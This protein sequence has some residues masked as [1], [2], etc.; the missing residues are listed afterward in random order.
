VRRVL[1]LWLLSLP[2][3]GESFVKGPYLQN[4][5]RN[6]ITVMWQSDAS[7]PGTVSIDGRVIEAPPATIHEVRVEGLQPGRRYA[8]QVECGGKTSG[9]ELATAPEPAEPFSFVVFGDTRSN[10]DSHR[11]MVERVRREVPDFFLLTGDMVDDGSRDT[12]WQT[13]FQI[14]REL[15][16]DNVVYPAVGNHDRQGRARTADAFRRFF[17]VP[18]D[19]PDPERYYSFK[20][21]NARFFVLD[22]NEYSFALTDQTAWLTREL[23]RAAADPEVVH[24][25]VVMHHPPFS[26]S[27]HGGHSELREMWTPIFERY[28]VD[29]V[30]SG[31][32]HCYSRAARNGVTY[33]VSGGGGAPLYP[34]DPRPAPQDVEAVVYFERTL[35]FLR[36]Q[37]VGQFVEVAAVR[38]DGTLIET[39]SW[40]TPP[41]LVAQA[42]APPLPVATASLA[43]STSRRVGGGR[44]GGCSVGDASGGAAPGLLLALLVGARFARRRPCCAG[45]PSAWPARP[46]R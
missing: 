9:G 25:F 22:S 27:I 34:R 10:S 23:E 29:A 42:P 30:F 28:R 5:S 11:A 31:H 38:E 6:G 35:H 18:A 39:L 3:W 7:L 15:L 40:G 45:S 33:L 13:F 46:R 4:V 41:V 12:E 19:S 14:E 32:D 21:G 17:S 20:Y 44:G 8:Y 2:A 24:R 1:A 26:V 37:V 43:P 16:R 36:V